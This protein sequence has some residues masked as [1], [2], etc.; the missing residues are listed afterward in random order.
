MDAQNN[1]R[2]L[3]TSEPRVISDMDCSS[4]APQ[5]RELMEGSKTMYDA[6]WRNG[7]GFQSLGVGAGSFRSG[8]TVGVATSPLEDGVV[9]GADF[10]EEAQGVG[11][12]Q[13]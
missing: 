1:L 11:S 13:C 8:L 6:R 7:N 2:N 12:V 9:G 4:R 3:E 10:V 5:K